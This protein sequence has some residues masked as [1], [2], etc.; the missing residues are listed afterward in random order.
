MKLLFSFVILSFSIL[1]TAFR[2][3]PVTAP[4]NGIWRATLS[5]DN[6]KLPILLDISKNADGKTY[7]VRIVNGTEKLNMD[8][9]YFQNDSLVIPMMMFDAKIVAKS[10]GDKLKGT[11]Y[12]YANGAVAGSLPFEAEQGG[13]L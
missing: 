12:R 8:S 13:R 7:M 5:R 11:Y 2:S 3:G 6:Q 10:T 1:S 4:K 9:A